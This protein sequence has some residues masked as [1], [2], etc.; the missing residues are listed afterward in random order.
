VGN[1]R[2]VLISDL[3]GRSNI[4][5]KAQNLGLKLTNDTPEL[6]A[7]LEAIIASVPVRPPLL[8]KV[9]PDLSERGLQAVIETCIAAG[10]AGLVV[11]NTTIDRP[12][13]LADP[14]AAESGGLSGAPLFARST[15]VLAQACQ[16]AGGRLVLIGCGGIASGRDA[17]AKI[18]AGAHL[19]QLYTAFAYQGPALVGRLRTELAAA[20]RADGFDRITD[21]VGVDAPKV[22]RVSCS[23]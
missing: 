18:R 4:V 12:P 9:A 20:L 15:A 6:R 8:V 22:G 13:G 23:I 16:M 14:Q 21:A 10:I 19:V 2:N 1:Q 11:S 3:A 5:M 17:L 7:I